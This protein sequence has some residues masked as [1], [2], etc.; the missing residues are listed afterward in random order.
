MKK[1]KGLAVLIFAV[2]VLF[3]SGCA[4]GFMNLIKS[5]DAGETEKARAMIK[6][7]PSVLTDEDYYGMTALIYAASNGKLDAV[8]LFV[9]EGADVNLAS[10]SSG[11]TPI[12][13]AAY[14]E[15]PAVVKYLLSK[16]ANTE[17]AD[18]KG[19]TPLQYAAVS[20]AVESLKILIDAKAN[21]RVRDNEGLSA[22]QLAVYYGRP[23]ALKIL[24]NSGLYDKQTNMNDAMVF[25][26][27]GDTKKAAAAVKA[28]VPGT[29]LDR[30]D[31]SGKTTLIWAAMT[32]YPDLV[33]VL[34][35][36]GA[37]IN[38]VDTLGRSALYWA[39]TNNETD[40][41]R[42]LLGAGADVNATEAQSKKTVL[43]IAV[44][45]KNIDMVKTILN[46]RP[47]LVMFDDNNKSALYYADKGSEI[48]K[49]LK[50]AG[51]R[52]MDYKET[53]PTPTPVPK[54][55]VDDSKNIRVYK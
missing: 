19:R 1:Q 13:Y 42:A 7:N 31:F 23:A 37:A 50:G 39:V 20:G 9:E 4:A 8:K 47:N 33:N 15:Q 25:M 46:S 38:N 55:R 34:I 43:H 24:M 32:K 54:K 40:M 35:T 53:L 22:A 30:K 27:N 6:E 5:V 14:N 49:M 16:K 3:L 12:N 17:L 48:Q 10:K 11:I 52:Y 28:L 26:A 44:Q 2:A 41:A 51:A 21:G 45:N 18:I 36:K 29:S